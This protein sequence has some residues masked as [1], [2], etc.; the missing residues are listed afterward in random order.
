M[1]PGFNSIQAVETFLLVILAISQTYI[2]M[3][4]RCNLQKYRSRP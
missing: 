3:S 1:I 4:C 2:A